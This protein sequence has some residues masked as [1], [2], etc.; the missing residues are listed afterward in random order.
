MLAKDAINNSWD[1]YS[2]YDYFLP[3]INKGNLNPYLKKK[4]TNFTKK[5][6]KE[7]EADAKEINDEIINKS[8]EKGLYGV[9]L[10]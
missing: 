6:I 1:F 7:N 10:K 8:I 4:I 2:V 9:L 5:L 3:D